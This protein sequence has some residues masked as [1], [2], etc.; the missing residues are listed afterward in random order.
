MVQHTN[1]NIIY[2]INRMNGG[3]GDT[4]IST[5][6]RKQKENIWHH[7]HFHGKNPQQSRKKENFLN[8][9]KGVYNKPTSNMTLKV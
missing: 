1:I 9:I 5:D 6:A 7:T 4:V 8:I 2:H 3:K